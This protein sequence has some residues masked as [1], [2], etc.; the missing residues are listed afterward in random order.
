MAD[1]HLV[2]VAVVDVG[3]VFVIVRQWQVSV[4]QPREHFDRP[5]L[6]V[7]IIR[8]DRVRVLDRGVGPPPSRYRRRQRAALRPQYQLLTFPPRSHPEHDQNNSRGG[9]PS[10]VFLKKEPGDHGRCDEFEIEE[11]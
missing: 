6:V 7:R 9:T 4:T 10:D 2:P 8:V 11:Q 3:Q 1:V 5:G